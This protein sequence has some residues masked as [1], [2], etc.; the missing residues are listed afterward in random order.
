MSEESGALESVGAMSFERALGELETIVRDLETG[1]TGLED[2][3]QAY[4][5]GVALKK[6][7]ENRLR[8]AHSRIEKITIDGNG[9]VS[10]EP[11]SVSGD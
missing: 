11:F 3:I 9:R 4:E 5:R 2:S 10:T 6:H 7:C 8:E 1:K